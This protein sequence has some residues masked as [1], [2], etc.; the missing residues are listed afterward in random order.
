MQ[1]VGVYLFKLNDENTRKVCKYVVFT[2]NYFPNFLGV[3]I[4][5]FE[6]ANVGWVN[7]K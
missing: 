3:S 5:H 4:V 7:S 6:Q 2:L 1:T